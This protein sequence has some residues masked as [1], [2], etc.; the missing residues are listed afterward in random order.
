MIEQRK[1]NAKKKRFEQHGDAITTT[2]LQRAVLN[3]KA[4]QNRAEQKK[5]NDHAKIQGG[6][7]IPCGNGRRQH[8][9]ISGKV[10]DGLMAESEQA[11]DINEASE[12][13]QNPCAT[14][15]PSGQ[16]RD[17]YSHS[18]VTSHSEHSDWKLQA[19]KICAILAAK[20]EFDMELEKLSR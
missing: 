6:R 1:G 10:R 5:A 12:K 17:H 19:L 8:G 14:P 15:K 20:E 11:N 16:F 7:I 9:G 13:G 3:D 18:A 4:A 2:E